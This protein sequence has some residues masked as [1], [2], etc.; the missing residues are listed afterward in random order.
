MCSRKGKNGG[1]GQKTFG[2]DHRELSECNRILLKRVLKGIE[3]GG[4][5]LFSN[6]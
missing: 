1:S 5:R 4:Y 3:Y 2:K 6:C